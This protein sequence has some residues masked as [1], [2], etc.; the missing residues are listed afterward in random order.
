M[1]KSAFLE[2]FSKVGL[3]LPLFVLLVFFSGNGGS[4]KTFTSQALVQHLMEQAGGG[5]D[6][7][8][9]KVCVHFSD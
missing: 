9:C 7:D 6:S 1:L 4:G 3:C 5:L 8:I 2:F